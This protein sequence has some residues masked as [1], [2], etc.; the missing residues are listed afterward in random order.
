MTGRPFVENVRLLGVVLQHFRGP[1]KRKLRFKPKQHYKRI[2]GHRQEYTR[3]RI[4]HIEVVPP[5]F[6]AD[7]TYDRHKY[8]DCIEQPH[9]QQ[10]HQQQPHHKQPFI[11][12]PVPPPPLL[13]PPS[14]SWSEGLSSY[15]VAGN[16]LRYSDSE[17]LHPNCFSTHRRRHQRS[18]ANAQRLPSIRHMGTSTLLSAEDILAEHTKTTGGSHDLDNLVAVRGGMM[19]S[20]SE[21]GATGVDKDV[22][23]V[24]WLESLIE[25]G[26]TSGRCVHGRLMAYTVGGYEGKTEDVVTEYECSDESDDQLRVEGGELRDGGKGGEGGIGSGDYENDEDN[27]S[28]FKDDRETEN[29]QGEEESIYKDRTDETK[30][31]NNNNNNIILDDITLSSLDDAS[32]MDDGKQKNRTRLTSLPPLPASRPSAVPLDSPPSHIQSYKNSATDTST[33][34]DERR[35]GSPRRRRDAADTTTTTTTG[36]TSTAIANRQ[37]IVEE[38]HDKNTTRRGT[39]QTALI[40]SSSSSY[41]PWKGIGG[42]FPDGSVDR[43]LQL[44]QMYRLRTNTANC[45][46]LKNFLLSDPV[47]CLMQAINRTLKPSLVL[48]GMKDPKSRRRLS[49]DALRLDFEGHSPFSH[50]DPIVNSKMMDYT[51]GN[52]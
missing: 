34:R 11:S 22:H 16:V 12:P 51:V 39:T 42:V 4:E 35:R 45:R 23:R 26:C 27:D 33:G 31:H 18:D 49:R 24:P 2:V 3:V 17:N 30:G 50:F 25:E 6:T 13:S 32:P 5:F 43:R 19:T 46:S 8:S 7:R 37:K 48:K 47:Y 10:P 20:S 52:S 29:E 36:S 38:A 14:A 9:Q 15:G 28:V 21:D 1:K 41:P 44:L 40:S